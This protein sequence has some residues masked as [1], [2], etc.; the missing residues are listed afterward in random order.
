M[1]KAMAGRKAIAPI[2]TLIELRRALMRITR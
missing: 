2:Y 1:I